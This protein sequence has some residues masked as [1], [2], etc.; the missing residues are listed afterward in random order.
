[1]S[2]REYKGVIFDLYGTLVESFRSQESLASIT[3]MAAT[4][5]APKD[6]FRRLWR[7]TFSDRET[8]VFRTIEENIWHVCQR[9]GIQRDASQ[10]TAAARLRLDLYRRSLVP[11]PG[12]V[13]TLVALRSAGFRIGLVSNA[14]AQTNELWLETPMAPLVDAPV[15][16][17]AAGMSK[18]DPRIYHLALEG[19]G[20][21]ADTCLFVGDGGSGELE[22]ARRVGLHPVLIRVPGDDLD[23]P[24]R[25]EAKEWQGPTVSAISEVLGL[26]TAG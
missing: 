24:H 4:L 19:L 26:V 14:S 3:E 11:R 20:L 13:E 7:E 25:P 5:E 16:S 17:C 2:T 21:A 23:D 12:S 15:F 9:L 8:G 18:P 1:M 6:E 10:V 22:G